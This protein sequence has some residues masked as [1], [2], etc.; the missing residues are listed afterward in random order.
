MSERC[1]ACDAMV[2]GNEVY[3]RQ[4][5][6]PLVSNLRPP[7]ARMRWL[8]ETRRL[9]LVN[10]IVCVLPACALAVPTIA[11]VGGIPLVGFGVLLGVFARRAG[12]GA[13]VKLAAAQVV[14]VAI[15]VPLVW[16]LRNVP[17]LPAIT[18][19]LALL[20]WAAMFG[21]SLHVWQNPPARDLR[22]QCDHCGY[23]LKGQVLPRCPE[24]GHRFDPARL[25]L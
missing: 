6:A 3:C 25:D 24:C 22:L 9:L 15:W 16:T 11:P 13:A 2:V 14:V 1:P 5:A 19:P 18:L 21:A 8:V 10:C 20:L 23:W 12:Y 4:C 7:S 17:F